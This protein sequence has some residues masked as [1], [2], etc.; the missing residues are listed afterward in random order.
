MMYDSN[1]AS[2]KSLL[3]FVIAWFRKSPLVRFAREGT[4]R[5]GGSSFEEMGALNVK[6]WSA[7]ASVVESAA[8]DLMDCSM[9]HVGRGGKKAEGRRKGQRGVKLN[10]LAEVASSP[11]LPN[12]RQHEMQCSSKFAIF[13]PER[14]TTSRQGT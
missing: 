10:G 7:A 12:W 11:S 1:H 5:E 9:S 2:E 3:T 8:E 6:K 13:P 4:R 14:L